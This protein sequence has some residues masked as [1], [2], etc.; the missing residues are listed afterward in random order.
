MVENG[1]VSEYKVLPIEASEIVDTNGAGDAFVGGYL[2]QLVRAKNGVR[3]QKR[4]TGGMLIRWPRAFVCLRLADPRQEH[5]GVH[6]HCAVHGPRD[7]DAARLHLPGLWPGRVLPVIDVRKT[8][9]MGGER[10]EAGRFWWAGRFW[11]GAGWR[12]DRLWRGAG[13]MP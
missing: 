3:A 8:I 2:A 9:L 12:A 5:A 4:S 1:Q 7:P 6:P 10:T 13:P 11:R